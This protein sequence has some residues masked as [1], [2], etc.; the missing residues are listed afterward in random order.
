MKIFNTQIQEMIDQQNRYE[1]AFD[2]YEGGVPEYFAT[3]Q[4]RSA[5]RSTVS[6]IGLNHSRTVVT[7]MLDRLEINNVIGRT[8]EANKV[9]EKINDQNNL[10]LFF[11]DLFEKASVYGQAFAM[12]W[13]DSSG[14]W[15]LSAYSPETTHVTY[16]KEDPWKMEVA[17]RVWQ[18]GNKLRLN[19]FY[20]DRIEKYSTTAEGLTLAQNW[21]LIDTI[22]NP[23]G[24][25]PIYHLRNDLKIGRP[26]H[27]DAYSC[28]DAVNK[29]AVTHLYTVDY[30]G[31]PQRYALANMESTGEAVDF[32][33]GDADRGNKEALSSDPGDLWYLKGVHNVGQF[34]TAP[35]ES[36]WNP[37]KDYVRT[38]AAITSTPIHYFEPTG[39][40]PSGNALRA[41]EAPLVAK[42]KKRRVAYTSPIKKMFSFILSAEEVSTTQVDINWSELESIDIM[43]QWDL[44]LKKINAGMPV[45]Q[46]L[47]E[48]GYE[49]AEIDK[50]IEWKLEEKE[51]ALTEYKR[52]ANTEPLV[53]TQT[54][55]D[56][57][58]VESETEGNK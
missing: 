56:E 4:L 31:A 54:N 23:F 47:L 17:I 53:R 14:D 49:E 20:E 3:P 57:T 51:L 6:R 26:E 12:A 22:E 42:I 37:I 29:L 1:T 16:S 19:A 52:A 15:K 21:T 33:D 5:V 36:F 38:M 27:F 43:D 18:E 9:I 40:I 28:Q 48:N 24:E 41:A 8:K 58:N 50:I 44:N 46:V 32:N 2:Y 39:N 25:I 34:P 11:G 35:A 7:E 30:M 10:D 45:R 13:P 55:N